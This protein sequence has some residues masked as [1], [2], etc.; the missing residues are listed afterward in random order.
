MCW[1][2]VERR[3]FEQQFAG[4]LRIF[5]AVGKDGSGLAAAVSWALSPQCNVSL[6]VLGDKVRLERPLVSRFAGRGHPRPAP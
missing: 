4:Q 1:A 3:R 6:A 5:E 2:G